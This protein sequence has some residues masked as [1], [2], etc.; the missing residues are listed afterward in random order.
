MPAPKA[1]NMKARGERRTQASAKGAEYESQRRAPN[2]VQ[3]QRRGISKPGASAEHS[4]APKARNM[5][6]RASAEHS[7][8]P[9]ARNMKARASAEHS[10]A[11]KAR[12]K[13]QGKRRA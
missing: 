2:T 13:T 7:P 5:K 10:P 1:R 9:K 3:R 11:P 12:N 6:V 8:A 4:P